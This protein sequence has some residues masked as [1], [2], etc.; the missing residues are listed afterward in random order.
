MGVEEDGHAKYGE[1]A[2]PGTQLSPALWQFLRD[3]GDMMS[4]FIS[5]YV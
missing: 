4:V 3:S 1:V 5:V 2:D